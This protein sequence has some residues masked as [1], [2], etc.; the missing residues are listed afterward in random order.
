MDSMSR[1]RRP[2]RIPAWAERQRAADLAW[3]SENLHVLWPAAQT[4]YET[5][6]RGALVID[7]LTVVEHEGGSGNPMMYA[8]QEVIEQRNDQDALRIVREYDPAW[9]LVT[10]LLKSENRESVYRVGVPSQRPSK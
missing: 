7:T 2:Q 4:G 9:E 6:G 5:M 8:P 3:I 10:I 1:E